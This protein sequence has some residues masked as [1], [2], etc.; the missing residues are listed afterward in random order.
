MKVIYYYEGHR[1]DCQVV[2]MYNEECLLMNKFE[3]QSCVFVE[4][5]YV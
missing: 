2:V 4:S 1:V 3:N 5:V